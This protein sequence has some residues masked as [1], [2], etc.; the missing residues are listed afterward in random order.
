MRRSERGSVLPLA[1][2]AVLMAGGGAVLLG[3]LGE[4]AVSRAAA[5]TAADAAALAGAADGEAAARQVA[6]DNGATVLRYETMGS[7]TRVTV[8]VRSAEA[9]G[10]ARRDG[11]HIGENNGEHN[12]RGSG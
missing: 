1:A 5:R 10:R 7:D 9:V 6:A 12:T 8:R 2:L 4:A 3:R 11:E